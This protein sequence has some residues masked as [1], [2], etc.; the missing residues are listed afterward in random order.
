MYVLCAV[1]PPLLWTK[2]S[3]PSL[4][5]SFR[6][7]QSLI[8]QIAADKRHDFPPT[9]QSRSQDEAQAAKNLQRGLAA[10]VQDISASFRKKQRVYLESS[11]LLDSLPFV[12]GTPFTRLLLELQGHSIKN[13]DL[14]VAAGTVSLNS[15]DG[16]MALEDDMNAAVGCSYCCRV[17]DRRSYGGP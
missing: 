7:C 2:H 4:L 17:F 5:Q 10:K 9:A 8:E 6:R 15:A 14:L 3:Q 1:T 13:Q 11:S 12:I 16:V